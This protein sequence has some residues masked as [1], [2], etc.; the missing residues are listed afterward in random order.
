[1]TKDEFV[2][3]R[4]R[5]DA[6]LYKILCILDVCVVVAFLA[7]YAFALMTGRAT[8][9]PGGILI[10]LAV[11]L[12][13]PA[14]FNTRDRYAAAARE[15]EVAAVDSNAPVSDETYAAVERLV[16]AP[17]Q[18]RQQLIA[19]GIMCPLLLA[20]AAVIIYVSE[21]VVILVSSG[22]I[23]GL[24]GVALGILAYRAYRDLKVAKE[25]ED[26]Q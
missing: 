24:M 25:L 15:L 11:A 18:L 20:G 12:Q 3:K 14:M 16:I 19:Y 5:D 4:M 13:L 10:I 22:V 6:N 8:T 21:G 17:K 23:M 1:M 26:V 7:L 9:Q 2:L